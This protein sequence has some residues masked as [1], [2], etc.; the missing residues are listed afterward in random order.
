MA[1]SAAG[2]TPPVESALGENPETITATNPEGICLHVCDPDS[3]EEVC[4]RILNSAELR[5]MLA[6]GDEVG[7]G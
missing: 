5:E 2:A 4:E 1:G 7:T 3:Y 6:D